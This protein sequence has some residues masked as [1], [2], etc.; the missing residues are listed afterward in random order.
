MKIVY[1]P[2]SGNFDFV[3][4][5]V[6]PGAGIALST[7]SA[8][9]TSITNNSANWNTAYG[10]GN[11]AGLYLAL[12]GTADAVSG[13]TITAG[14]SISGTNTGDNAANSS[15][16]YIGTTAHALNRASAAETLAG[17]TLTTPDIGAA[18]ATSIAIGANTLNT[19]E[20]AFLDGLD[21]AVKKADSPTFAGATIGSASDLL[22]VTSGVVAGIGSPVKN[23]IPI[24]N[25]TT[26]VWA[27]AG[28]TFTF[29]I[30]TF[31]NNGGSTTVLIGTGDWKAIGALSFSATYNNGT[32]DATPYI[33]KTSPGWSSN[34]NMTG[35]GYVGP[36]TNTEAVAYPSVGGSR[37]FTLNAAIGAETSTSTSTFVFYNYRF[38]GVSTNTSLTEAQVE[39]LTNTLSNSRTI[40]SSM[41]L[42]AGEY[43][44]FV[45]PTRLGTPS[46]YTI[47]GF[48]GGWI[49]VST[50]LSITNSASFA[51]NYTVYRTLNHSLGSI[52]YTFT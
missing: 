7:G 17:L 4:S 33:S 27:A 37:A 9:D 52:T 47:N 28:T 19:T 13:L 10:W 2:L 20:W 5:M 34:L 51:E 3:N 24:W 16:M 50:T 48:A 18:T 32:P 44:Y 42:G 8:W 23:Y 25:G 12:H 45:Y 46:G 11:H 36:T 21:Q 22:K 29:S 1:N 39:A 6:Y 26:V 35:A 14:A 41:T 40:S 31:T 30:A 38:T 49:E 15:S 43:G